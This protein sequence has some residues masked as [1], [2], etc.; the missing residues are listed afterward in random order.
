MVPSAIQPMEAAHVQRAGMVHTVWIVH[1]LIIC[2]VKSA[3]IHANATKIIR[4]AVTRGLE[5]A[6]ARLA[7]AVTCAIVHV[8]S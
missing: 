5:N 3:I 8:R 2:L 1:V 6:I 7:G 4:E